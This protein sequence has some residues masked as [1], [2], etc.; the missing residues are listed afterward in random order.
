MNRFKWYRKWKGGYWIFELFNGWRKITEDGY[1]MFKRE[2]CGMENK[3]IEN[4]T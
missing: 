4:W 2:R 1:K 3:K